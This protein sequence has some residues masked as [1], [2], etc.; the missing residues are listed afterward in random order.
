MD[1]SGREVITV[2]EDA[3]LLDRE[4]QFHLNSAVN[5]YTQ[6][7]KS[8]AYD[9]ILICMGVIYAAVAVHAIN[10]SAGLMILETLRHSEMYEGYPA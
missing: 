5:W 8:I 2:N 7:V 1:P 10:V 3:Y 4:L 9:E 6:G